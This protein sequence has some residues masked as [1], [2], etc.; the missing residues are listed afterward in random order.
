LISQNPKYLQCLQKHDGI[1]AYTAGDGL[2]SLLNQS[3]RL[4]W[5]STN[6]NGTQLRKLKKRI[7]IT[8]MTP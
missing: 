3:G 5:R 6:I 4:I 8:Q 2:S 7:F 1:N